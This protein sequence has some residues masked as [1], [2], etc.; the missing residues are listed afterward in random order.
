[1]GEI[2]GVSKYYIH[3]FGKDPMGVWTRSFLYQVIDQSVYRPLIAGLI[4]FVCYVVQDKKVR[5]LSLIILIPML[6]MT[7]QGFMTYSLPAHNWWRLAGPTLILFLPFLAHLIYTACSAI[8][9][10]RHVYY[11][12]LVIV[13]SL[14][15]V[16]F[17]TEV[18]RMTKISSFFTR[19][20]LR[21]GIFLKTLCL[22]G[23]DKIL[24]DTSTWSYSNLMIASNMPANK[25][26][27]NTGGY[28]TVPKIGVV[29]FNKGIDVIPL[30]KMGIKYFVFQTKGRPDMDTTLNANISDQSRI[31]NTSKAL[32]KINQ[33]GE[34]GIFS[35]Q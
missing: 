24:L 10:N 32:R 7:I 35:L 1:M 12:S 30:K 25:Y 26:I 13:T 34:W 27:F 15:V 17:Y 28:P 8:S 9:V 19:D 31:L 20:H 6:G 22:K 23:N 29:D 18:T 5:I 3:V 16:A 14:F 33:I 2:S 21:V 4:S 11:V